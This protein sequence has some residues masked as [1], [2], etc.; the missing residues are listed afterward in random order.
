MNIDISP[1]SPVGEGKL[2]RG[3]SDDMAAIVVV[4]FFAQLNNSASA[5]GQDIG[6]TGRS[7]QQW[8]WVTCKRMEID[9]IDK[10]ADIVEREL[11]K[12]SATRTLI[13]QC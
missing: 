10:R 5:E 7:P 12:V 3:E 13:L 6:N 4:K 9:I 2:I 11:R 1:S 8:S